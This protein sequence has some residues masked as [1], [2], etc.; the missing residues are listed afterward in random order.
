MHDESNQ[1]SVSTDAGRPTMSGVENAAKDRPV[2]AFIYFIQCNGPDGPIKIGKAKFIDKRLSELQ[3]GCPYDLALIG[4]VL[5]DDADLEE[6]RLHGCFA[7]HKIR[8]EWFRCCD[9]ILAAARALDEVRM[10]LAAERFRALSAAAA[11]PAPPVV[12]PKPAAADWKDEFR[13]HRA[14]QRASGNDPARRRR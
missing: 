2:P 3:I 13:A 4:H 10:A 7:R 12:V 14:Q 1:E 11:E 6:R 9:E 8:G 5:V